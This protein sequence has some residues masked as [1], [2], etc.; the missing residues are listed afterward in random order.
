MLIT[1]SVYPARLTYHMVVY[2]F[3][4]LHRTSGGTNEVLE[5]KGVE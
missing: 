1:A 2:P 5:E 3:Y 4:Q